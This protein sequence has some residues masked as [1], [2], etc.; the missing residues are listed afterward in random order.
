MGLYLHGKITFD[1]KTVCKHL[2]LKR[3]CCADPEMAAKR[4]EVNKYL[5]F[6]RLMEMKEKMEYAG[7][8][9]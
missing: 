6:E 8:G 7:G 2:F 3:A 4:A 1:G 5:D 9:K